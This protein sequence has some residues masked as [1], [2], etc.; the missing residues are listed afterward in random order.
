MP[1]KKTRTCPCRDWLQSGLRLGSTEESPD[2]K[3]TRLIPSSVELLLLLSCAKHAPHLFCKL[4]KNL[5]QNAV[6]STVAILASRLFH[7]FRRWILTRLGQSE[8]RPD[9]T[10]RFLGFHG[11]RDRCCL[12]LL[13]HAGP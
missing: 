10:H 7:F 1:P 12:R 4:G 13:L 5:G 9:R 8:A 6:G 2:K 11:W 3:G